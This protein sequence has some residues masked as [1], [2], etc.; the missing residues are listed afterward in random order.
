MFGDD[1]SSGASNASYISVLFKQG[2][3]GKT[4][5]DCQVQTVFQQSMKCMGTYAAENSWQENVCELGM[6]KAQAFI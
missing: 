1:L 2:K 6:L 3:E 5:A 4:Q